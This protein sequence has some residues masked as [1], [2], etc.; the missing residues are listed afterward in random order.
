MTIVILLVSSIALSSLGVVF[1][2][3]AETTTP[4]ITVTS[5]T[6]TSS[7]RFGHSFEIT[8]TST[9]E[10]SNVTIELY[11]MS[12]YF[13]FSIASNISNTG[14]YDW[15]VNASGM[16]CRIKVF[17]V[18]DP[19]VCNSSALF[20]IPYISVS[21]PSTT[22][23]WST[24]AAYSI[25]WYSYEAGDSVSIELYNN[26]SYDSTISESTGSS[27]YYGSSYLWSVPRE[28]TS[29]TEY[30]IRVTSLADPL[31]SGYSSF[32]TIV[33]QPYI[34]VTSPT[35]ADLVM[36]GHPCQI[37]WMVAGGVIDDVSLELY[38]QW[39]SSVVIIS[40]TPNTGSYEWAVD[41]SGSDFRIKVS[42][43]A[44]A[45]FYGYS[46]SFDILKIVV[47]APSSATTWYTGG[48]LQIAW[49]P[50]GA[51]SQF[52]V[53]LCK[54]GENASTISANAS[55]YSEMPSYYYWN[56]PIETVSGT[57]YQIR[58]TSLAQPLLS[59]FSSFFTIVQQ[60]YINV[61]S[62]HSGDVWEPSTMR[63]ITWDSFGAG[64]I[65]SIT[66]I[67]NWHGSQSAIAYNAA[68][69][70]VYEWNI[71][72]E[73]RA[74]P[75][76]Q[77]YITNGSTMNQLYDWSDYFEIF[78]PSI[79]VT[80]PRYM[81]SWE[82]GT[83]HE[84]TWNSYD[85]G[86]EV[87]IGL[88]YNQLTIVSTTEN[89]GSFEWTI[90]FNLQT[91]DYVVVRSVS[92]N[93]VF[94]YSDYFYVTPATV[95]WLVMRNPQDGASLM[96]G[97]C[98]SV[99]WFSGSSVT[100]PGPY[101]S[102]ELYHEGS[103]AS[104]IVPFTANP[105]GYYAP[106]YQWYVPFDVAVGGGYQIKVASLSN[107]SVFSY[108]GQFSVSDPITTSWIAVH[109]PSGTVYLGSTCAVTWTCGGTVGGTVGIELW[110]NGALNSAIALAA[111]NVGSFAW[112]I[113]SALDPSPYYQVKVVSSS[114]SSVYGLGSPFEIVPPS[115]WITVNGTNGYPMVNR[116]TTISWSSGNNPGAFVEI[117]LYKEDYVAGYSTTSWISSIASN[118]SNDGE[119]DWFVSL[120]SWCAGGPYILKVT[121][122]SESWV[123]G[124]QWIYILRSWME[125]TSPAGGDTWGLGTTHE[126][127]WLSNDTGD[128]VAIELYFGDDSI[129]V[130]AP[131][132]ANDGSF[133]WSIPAS[134]PVSNGYRIWIR[135][136]LNLENSDGYW[137]EPFLALTSGAV[138][139]LSV[140]RPNGGETWSVGNTASI[141]W[142]STG[143]IGDARIELFKSGGYVIT[144]AA[145]TA[146]DGSYQ[147]QLPAS[148]SSGDDYSVKVTSLIDNSV[149]DYC[150]SLFSIA[151]VSPKATITVTSPESGIAWEMSTSH[152]I[153]WT[154][155]GNVTWVKIELLKGGASV[156][157]IISNTSCDGS[158]EWVVP[159]SLAAGG[160]YRVRIS[161]LD[162]PTVK[163]ESGSAFSLSET[164]A[165]QGG[166]GS[167][168]LALYVSTLSIAFAAISLAVAAKVIRGRKE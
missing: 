105:T 69:D 45:S 16:D 21:S 135:S 147:W 39:S 15:M 121:S 67:D 164:A 54:G 106:S 102:L 63:S 70:G 152:L 162:D 154:W 124:I 33:Q 4:D 163:G 71:P 59:N 99:D 20:S 91:S 42:D 100:Y 101:V 87:S 123:Y 107:S 57:D 28:T 132:T 161:S 10:I 23:S 30:R 114:D 12:S 8:W 73:Q 68:N 104:T 108:S 92:K 156:G 117:D 115:P 26:E 159:D 79:N 146:D 75:Q 93:W 168:N 85:A 136:L 153:T 94:G 127:T 157:T 110:Q 160:D 143:D 131:D 130:L 3:S 158:F 27:G 77:V 64:D 22:D 86:P 103:Y 89:D 49:N 76:C 38:D 129:A 72:L 165:T 167:S 56:I 111:P 61:T 150:D 18:D 24:G 128:R 80:S 7:V 35:S 125:I 25:S 34:T 122:L 51:G 133:E 53:E 44:N 139:T 113:P 145:S 144:I 138:A 119:F 55:G 40:S 36:Y 155:S 120:P 60:P 149:S 142:S 151:G 48:Q 52:I 6:D 1:P 14:S 116:T 19:T 81:D 148:L 5:P 95:Q 88:R 112:S 66:L 31:I 58:V 126:I 90:P 9:G 37:S 50:Y 109:S 47:T 137:S 46:E 140:T 17:D 78:G 96:R 141:E 29:G 62:P 134:L 118:T 98:Y 32:F 13:L 82:A 74:S 84:I 65:V 97:T 2:V 43:V 83:T 11:M 166:G 41:R